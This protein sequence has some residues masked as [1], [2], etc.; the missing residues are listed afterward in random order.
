MKVLV[1]VLSILEWEY[2]EFYLATRGVGSFYEMSNCSVTDFV[3]KL[4][5]KKCPLLLK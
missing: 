5:F 2:H 4:N 3:G 1:G